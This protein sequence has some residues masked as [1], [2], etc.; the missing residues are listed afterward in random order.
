MPDLRGEFLR[1]TGANSHENQGNGSSVG[2]H[3]DGT[4]QSSFNIWGNNRLGII[5][6]NPNLPFKLYSK[7]DKE[8]SAINA[9]ERRFESYNISANSGSLAYGYTSRPTNTSVMYCIKYEP[10]CVVETEFLASKPHLWPEDTEVDLG[11]GLYG[12]RKTGTITAAAKTNNTIHLAIGKNI[13]NCGGWWSNGADAESYFNIG[14]S[15]TPT[16]GTYESCVSYQPITSDIR[17]STKS[18]VS[19]NNAGYMVWVTY[20]KE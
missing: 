5:T 4:E 6:I 20:T 7:A 17:L 3:Q 18:A 12:I 13:I 2:V 9:S 15:Y 1:G 10:T 19:R 11:N 14:Q 16:T 8:I